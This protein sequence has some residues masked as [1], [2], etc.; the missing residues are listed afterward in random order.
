MRKLILANTQVGEGELKALAAERVGGVKA[1]LAGPGKV[2]PAR[3]FLKADDIHK[4]PADK[5]P[6]ARVEFGA[7]VE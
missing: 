3:L 7:A 4:A 6:S 5:G 2:D 1:F